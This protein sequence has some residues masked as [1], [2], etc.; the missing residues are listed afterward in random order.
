M[1]ADFATIRSAYKEPAFLSNLLCLLII[2]LLEMPSSDKLLCIII[3]LIIYV[4]GRITPERDFSV[5][6]MNNK[7][8]TNYGGILFCR[9]VSKNSMMFWV[10]CS[11]TVYIDRMIVNV[12]LEDSVKP[13]ACG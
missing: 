2:G 13:L 8:W 4:F 3:V 7:E 5:S 11:T 10:I 1:R 12:V 9:L 6:A